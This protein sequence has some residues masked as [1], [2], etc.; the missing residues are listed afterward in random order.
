MTN[1]EVREIYDAGQVLLGAVYKHMSNNNLSKFDR[2]LG[3]VYELCDLEH[4]LCD[5]CDADCPTLVMRNGICPDC[6]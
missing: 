6:R 4:A 2:M 3:E 5:L 1:K